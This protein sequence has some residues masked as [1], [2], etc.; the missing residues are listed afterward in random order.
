MAIFSRQKKE[1]R[2]ENFLPFFVK[3]LVVFEKYFG[4]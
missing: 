4:Q 3:H 1:K 2:Q